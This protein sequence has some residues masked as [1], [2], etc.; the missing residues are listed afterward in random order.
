MNVAIKKLDLVFSQYVRLRDAD[1]HGFITCV[2]CRKETRWQDSNCCHY[3]DRKNMATRWHEEN[4]HA[5][6]VD[7]N[8][9][10][11][12]F[13][14]HEYGKFLDSTYGLGTCDKLMALAK[15]DVHFS[16]ADLE[17]KIIYYKL[18]VKEYGKI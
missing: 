7:C 11:K 14:I 1:V 15:T 8:W 12:G 5:G 10:N 3:A 16:N 17:E 4:N 13:H 9:H 2:S 6:C 18:R